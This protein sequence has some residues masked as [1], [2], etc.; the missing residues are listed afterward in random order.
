MISTLDVRFRDG[1]HIPSSVNPRMAYER[2]SG[3]R[4]QGHSSPED[5]VEDARPDDVPTH[6]AFTWDDGEA[7]E[8]FRLQEARHL[9]NSLIIIRSEEPTV[10][11]PAFVSVIARETF[12][13]AYISTVEAQS[14]DDYRKQMLAEAVSA[15]ISWKRRY[16]QLKE[17][18]RIFSVIDEEAP[19]L[20]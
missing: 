13:R 8:K 9:C 12:A 16:A 3:L 10:Q 17:L 11:A 4:E 14:D 19:K 2:I 1:S 5:I 20:S 18:A 6:G 15:I 7:A